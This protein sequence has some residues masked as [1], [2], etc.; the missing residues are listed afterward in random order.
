MRPSAASNAFKSYKDTFDV[1]LQIFC[2]TRF[3]RDASNA[4]KIKRPFNKKK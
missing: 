3:C 2:S 1:S 4:S